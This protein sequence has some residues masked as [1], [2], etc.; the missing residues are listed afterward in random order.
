M[1]GAVLSSSLLITTI[2]AS[3]CKGMEKI[4]PTTQGP[5]P[6]PKSHL[7]GHFLKVMKRRSLQ[8]MPD[9]AFYLFEKALGLE[10]VQIKCLFDLTNHD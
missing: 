9:D 6:I 10:R 3:P 1:P 5:L 2:A 4:W 8:Y 7:I